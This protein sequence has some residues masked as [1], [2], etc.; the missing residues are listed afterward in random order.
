MVRAVAVA[1]VEQG[2][3]E[4]RERSVVTA[5]LT[6]VVEVEVGSVR[7]RVEVA[8]RLEQKLGVAV[9]ELRQV[10]VREGEEVCWV[11][12]KR[13]CTDRIRPPPLPLFAMVAER[14]EEEEGGEGEQRVM[15]GQT[16]CARLARREIGRRKCRLLVEE[17]RTGGAAE[18]RDL[19]V[20][21]G[22]RQ[23]EVGVRQG[24]AETV[25]SVVEERDR[26][27]CAMRAEVWGVSCLTEAALA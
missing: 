23:E 5:D 22:Q 15:R 2:E 9:V 8:G 1:A 14:T 26:T 21:L 6:A 20:V 7:R 25:L 16:R 27:A 4:R 12:W 17:E 19:R 13:N 3:W 18:L 24:A 10:G 11:E